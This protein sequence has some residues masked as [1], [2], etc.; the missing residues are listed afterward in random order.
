MTTNCRVWQKSLEKRDTRTKAKKKG[1][2]EK[3]KSCK[4]KDQDTQNVFKMTLHVKVENDN[5]F[6]DWKEIG[7]FQ[8][9]NQRGV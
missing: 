5:E 9:M 8:K 2:L 1:S 7:E 4:L 3:I 6:E